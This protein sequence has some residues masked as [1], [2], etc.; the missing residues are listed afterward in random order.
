MESTNSSTGI[1]L[2]HFILIADERHVPLRRSKMWVR[3]SNAHELCIHRQLACSEDGWL[4]HIL[5]G[6]FA[7]GI[8]ACKWKTSGQQLASAGSG[9]PPECHRSA[10]FRISGLSP[11]FPIIR[12]RRRQ[13]PPGI[14][15]PQVSHA[16][17]SVYFLKKIWI[18]G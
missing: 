13:C 3:S 5:T 17:Q 10:A 1:I 15:H 2:H 4:D 18:F 12:R 8:F 6:L 9:W 16:V 7:Y 11:N 14:Y